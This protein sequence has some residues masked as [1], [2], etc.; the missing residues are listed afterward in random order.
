MIQVYGGHQRR[1]IARAMYAELHRIRPGVPVMHSPGPAQSA[2]ARALDKALREK[3]GP[4]MHLGK[5]AAGVD[6]QIVGS[7]RKD[8]QPIHE[9][10]TAQGFGPRHPYFYCPIHRPG[11]QWTDDAV[12]CSGNRRARSA[13]FG[14]AGGIGSDT[15]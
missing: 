5:M 8:L 1:G 4:R 15:R 11:G 12:G 10:L 14:L 9:E 6:V 2:D 7:R 13:S 3:F